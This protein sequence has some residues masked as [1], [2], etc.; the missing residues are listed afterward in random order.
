MT[1]KGLKNGRRRSFLKASF[2]KAARA[3]F[4]R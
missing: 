2:L 1:R 3:E 4:R